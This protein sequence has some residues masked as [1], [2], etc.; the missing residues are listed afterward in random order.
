M[1]VNCRYI[2]SFILL[3]LQASAFAQDIKIEFDVAGQCARILEEEP[4]RIRISSSIPL[5]RI[6]ETAIRQDTFFRLLA[7][8]YTPNYVPGEPELP[9]RNQ[10]IEYPP[11]SIP[12]INII[13]WREDTVRLI[14]FGISSKH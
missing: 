9:V 13:S 12:E 2:V 14:E 11:N 6:S 1:R 10:L 8:G 3:F 5:V 4:G 7:D